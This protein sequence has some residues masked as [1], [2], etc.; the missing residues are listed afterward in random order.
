MSM[1]DYQLA[2]KAIKVNSQQ[3]VFQIEGG[4]YTNP[5][6]KGLTNELKIVS[7]KRYD[8]SCMIRLEWLSK[9]HGQ[10]NGRTQV[11]KNKYRNML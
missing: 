1:F 2:M 4:I 11:E 5:K 8:E 7:V 6:Q 9:A 3:V 10:H